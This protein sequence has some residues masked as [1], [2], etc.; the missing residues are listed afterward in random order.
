LIKR[1]NRLAIELPK[2][3]HADPNAASVVQEL[4]GGKFGESRRLIIICTNRLTFE[5]KPN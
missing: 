4:L 2:P 5:V 1:I 3:P